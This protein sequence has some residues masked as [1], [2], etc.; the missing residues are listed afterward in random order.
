MYNPPKNLLKELVPGKET[1]LNISLLDDIY[2]P[3]SRP[4]YKVGVFSKNNNITV[5]P[6]YTIVTNNKIKLSGL[7]GSRGTLKIAILNHQDTTLSFDI[8]LQECPPGYLHDDTS[9]TCVCSANTKTLLLGIQRC[10][11]TT[12]QANL[13]QGYW[14]GYKVSDGERISA[15][16][17]RTSNCPLGYCT[18][19]DVY[20]KPEISLPDT[21]SVSE[22][23]NLICNKKP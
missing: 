12:F 23:N 3:I 17:F 5:S 6:G 14:A 8:T 11:L 10:N 18:N 19:E 7:P 16:K 1:N 4:V 15:D 9:H 22:L 20:Y 13:V 2:F 21:V